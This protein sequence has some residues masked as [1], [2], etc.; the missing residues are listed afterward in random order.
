MR[1]RTVNPLTDNVL[2]A[3]CGSGL[4]V[5][6][7]AEHDARLHREQDAREDEQEYLHPSHGYSSIRWS[8]R[9]G[10]R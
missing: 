2:R 10:H 5:H 4:L 3:N 7:P 6:Y 1:P 9:G 8:R